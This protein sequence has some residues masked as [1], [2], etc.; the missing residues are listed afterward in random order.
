MSYYYILVKKKQ[1]KQLKNTGSLSTCNL[2][3]VLSQTLVSFM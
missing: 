1:K 3:I 2:L